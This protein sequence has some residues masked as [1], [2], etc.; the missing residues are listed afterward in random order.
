M[1]TKVHGARRQADVICFLMEWKEFHAPLATYGSSYD[2][3]QTYDWSTISVPHSTSLG[4]AA[5]HLSA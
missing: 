4:F 1:L 2:P 5:C 3:V